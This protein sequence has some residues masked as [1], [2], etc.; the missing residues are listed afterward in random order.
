MLSDE[1]YARI[2]RNLRRDVKS[3]AKKTYLRDMENLIAEEPDRYDEVRAIPTST[4]HVIVSFDRT[5]NTH[6]SYD[7]FDLTLLAFTRLHGGRGV[8]KPTHQNRV[9]RWCNSRRSLL[10]LLLF[11]R[12]HFGASHDIRFSRALIVPYPRP[13]VGHQLDPD[14]L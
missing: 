12:R 2:F 14:G 1:D 8:F 4:R 3:K 10:R 6:F 7:Y 5:Y 13:A 9:I 11:M